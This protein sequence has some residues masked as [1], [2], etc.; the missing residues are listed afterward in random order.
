MSAPHTHLTT[1]IE[2]IVARLLA[3]VAPEQEL[4][5]QVA[6]QALPDPSAEGAWVPVVVIYLEVPLREPETSYYSVGLLA[7]FRL[8]EDQ[9]REAVTEAVTAL[10]ER[11]TQYLSDSAD[12]AASANGASIASGAIGAT[13]GATGATPPVVDDRS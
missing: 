12:S 11:R 10:A 3:E 1:R 13:V 4:V 9:L 2:A 8:T 7:P 5:W 6:F